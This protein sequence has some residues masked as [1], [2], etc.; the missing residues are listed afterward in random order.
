MEGRLQLNTNEKR[1]RAEAMGVTDPYRIYALDDM[2]RGDVIFAATG[3]TGG[4]LLDGVRFRRDRIETHT[5]LMSSTAKLVREIRTR[6]YE[7]WRSR[8]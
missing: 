6:H 3:V 2:V 8:P 5:L 7:P 4:S 1:A